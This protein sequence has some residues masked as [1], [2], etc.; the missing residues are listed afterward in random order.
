MFVDRILYPIETLGPGK[1]IVVWTVGCTKRCPNCANPE[2]WDTA[3]RTNRNITDL[4]QIIR[5][6]C[7]E[8]PV[9]GITFTGGDPLE[10]ADELLAL[11]KLIKDCVSDVLV[12]TGYTHN[13]VQLLVDNEMLE[14]LVSVLID[15]PYVDELNDDQCVLRGSSNQCICYFDETCRQRYEAY[16]QLGRKIQNIVMGNRMISVG[17]H[18]R[19]KD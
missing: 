18:N 10:Q 14:A 16:L 11:L 12:Y 3:G 9:D 19:K 1:R 6:L 15:G 2:L 4:A 8:N 5:N 13:E 17:I 7:R